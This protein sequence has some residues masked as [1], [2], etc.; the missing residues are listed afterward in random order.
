MNI[1]FLNDNAFVNGGAAKIAL[2]EVQALADAGHNV[3]LICGVGPVAD[4]LLNRPNLT[5]HLLGFPDINDDP[6]RL[7]AATFGLWN[8]RTYQ[9]VRNIL[10]S[11]DPASTV[12][13]VHSW[14]RAL[15]SS[16]IQAA[17][18]SSFE[19]V[20]TLH[21]YLLACPQ[22][23]FFLHNVQQNCMLKP[24]SFTCICTNCDA[25]S[26]S[27]KLFRVARKFVQ[28]EVSG[29]PRAVRNFIYLSETSIELLRPYL[30]PGATAYNLPNPIDV[31]RLPQTEVSDHQTFL[32]IGRLVPE[33]GATLF[34]R[35][36]AAERVPAQFIG[37][38]P[39]NDTVLKANPEAVLS[40]W[41]NHSEGMK[42]LRSARALVF[43]S[44]WYETL[45]LTVLEAASNG[46]PNIVPRGCAAQESVVDGVTGLLFK[47]GDESDLRQKI[48]QL[49]DPEIA[50]RMGKAAYERFWASP[51]L[52]MNVHARH[53]ET[54][55]RQML[56]QR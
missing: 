22:G 50:K 25:Q 19:I 38:G 8:P 33:K 51:E 24:M 52:T 6:N 9:Y 40:G 27:N 14:T 39:E 4:D 36:A 28:S 29:F 43:P 54:I 42:A 15:S 12:V 7:R 45:G 44:L 46:V 47:S 53:L 56:S 34:A 11:F 31:E 3:H 35:A 37:D 18:D 1:V 48:A 2:S 41:M 49:K 5:V 17:V 21:D 13:H 32:F 55:Y 20:V 26:Y 10:K 23:T 16:A 30:P